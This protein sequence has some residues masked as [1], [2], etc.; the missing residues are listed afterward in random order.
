[1]KVCKI[2][3]QSFPLSEFRERIRKGKTCYE[4]YC[5]PCEREYQK[6]SCKKRYYAQHEE[7]K[8]KRDLNKPEQKIKNREYYNKNKDR[9]QAYRLTRRQQDRENLSIYSKRKRKEDPVFRLRQYMSNNICQ[10][11][12]KNNSSKRGKSCLE[13]LGYSVKEL[14]EYLES[15]FEPWMNWNNHGKYR[16]DLWD[17]NDSS[18]WTWQMDHIIPQSK[19]PY[20]SMAHP[21]FVKCWSLNNLR[22]LSA[23]LNLIKGAKLTL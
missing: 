8:T 17:D 4:C 3:K 2:C 5:K 10:I 14:K 23:K 13:F 19:L 9:L 16:L 15:Q 22:P 18:T 12:I 6:I 20:D 7:R 21:N 1:M 11:L